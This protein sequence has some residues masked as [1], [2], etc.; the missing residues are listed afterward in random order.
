VNYLPNIAVENKLGVGCPADSPTA[1][2]AIGGVLGLLYGFCRY[3]YGREVVDQWLVAIEQGEVQA[4]AI[5][6]DGWKF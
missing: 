2:A 6:E 1:T 4:T 3:V 5:L